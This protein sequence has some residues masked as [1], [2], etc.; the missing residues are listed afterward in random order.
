[1]K[2]Y[3]PCLAI[4][5]AGALLA[6]YAGVALATAPSSR[7]GQAIVIVPKTQKAPPPPIVQRERGRTITVPLRAACLTA[8]VSADHGVPVAC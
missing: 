4:C 1:M 6:L 5:L 2:S 3:A 7:G 8:V